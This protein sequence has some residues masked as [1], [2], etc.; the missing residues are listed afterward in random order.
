MRER[1]YMNRRTARENAFY[2]A[3]SASFS[4]GDIA[5]II[6][7]SRETGD[8]EVDAFGE[9]MVCAYFDHA[10]Q[11]D[12]EIRAHLRNWTM[13]RLPRVSLTAMRLAVSEMLYMPESPA[14]V[15]INEAVELVKRFGGEEDYQF[16]NGVLG[17]IAREKKLDTQPQQ[18]TV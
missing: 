1:N 4:G 6:A 10:A 9:K 5:Q 16:V 2:A 8:H 18:E 13:E 17:A 12:D 11:I 15:V 7:Q 14:S 3:F